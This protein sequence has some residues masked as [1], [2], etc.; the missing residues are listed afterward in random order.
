MLAS[1]AYTLHNPG[2]DGPGQTG[3]RLSFL[4][5]WCTREISAL[6]IWLFAM[7]GNKVSWREDGKVYRLR[8]DG[9]VETGGGTDCLDKMAQ[10]VLRRLKG[11]D[12]KRLEELTVD[13]EER[14]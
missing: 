11:G 2:H 3:F 14:S 7:L 4:T 8:R 13:H 5:A 9:K 12:M 10:T 6:P 1:P